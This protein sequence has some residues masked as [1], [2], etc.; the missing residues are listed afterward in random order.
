MKIKRFLLMVLLGIS[1]LSAT[2]QKKEVLFTI[3]NKP[4]YT[5]E[6]IR[7]YNKNLDLVKDDSQK[8]IDNYLDLYLAY[9]MKVNK[10]YNLGLD[11]NPKYINELKS[12]RNQLSKNYLT[13]TKVTEELIKEAYDRSLK[14]IK[15][16]HILILVDENAT[17]QDTLKAYQKIKSIRE[18]A[19]KGED[20]GK[21][22]QELSEDPSAK[23]NKGDLGYFSVFRMV[24]PFENGAYNTKKG[25]ISEPVRTRF[26][27]HLIKVDDIRDNRGEI[28]IAHIMLSKPDNPEKNKEVQDKIN[29]IYQK[30]QQGE[31]F[32]DLA[33][34]FSDDKSS[35]SKGGKLARIASGQLNSVIFEEA[36]FSI[37]NE[38][39]YT[40]PIETE[41]GWHIIKLLEKHPVKTFEES[42]SDIENRI[43]RDER[44]RRIA[45][46]MNRKLE[47]KYNPKK[48]QAL[49]KKGTELITETYYEA[50][51]EVP[52]N[53][54][55]FNKVI[56]TIGRKNISGIEF[57][58]FIKSQQNALQ[59]VKPLTKLKETII[60]NF[61]NSNLHT[62]YEENLE[63]EFEDFKH[64]MDEYKEGLLLF[65]LMEKEIWQ[66]AQI[67]T[68]GLEEFYNLNKEKYKWNERL[69]A[70]VASSVNR[71]FVEQTQKF[72]QEGKSVDFIKQELN[73]DAKINIMID[74]GFFEQGSSS[75]PKNY[76]LSLGVSEIYKDGDYYYVIE[77][78]E[79]VPS[80]IKTLEEAKG[81]LVSDYQQYLEENWINSLKQE[82]SYKVNDKVLKKV[83]KQLK[84]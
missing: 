49:F 5:D 10:A 68:V 1:S 63:N 13:D 28:T 52:E 84:K 62:Y 40:Q 75:L 55:D 16:S 48:N 15:A 34:Q 56:L 29:M 41:F 77:G 19:L 36:A 12:Y 43:K 54:D 3:D 37:K 51:F 6:F 58:N 42:K 25:E 14:E 26:G 60:E 67:D 23:E 38:G 69:N 64:I 81:R 2:A 21:L 47:K 57:L 78:K 9:K 82:F 80:S 8:D 73:K 45:E 7:V 53:T 30:L 74:Q 20:F 44:S 18:R 70:V 66:R 32:E 17:P 22:A 39:E 71:S 46:S 27:Y 61:I 11:K 4:Y 79:I 65:D 50:P 59:R 72:M 31:K 35:A 33:N 24:Y 83:K 76:K